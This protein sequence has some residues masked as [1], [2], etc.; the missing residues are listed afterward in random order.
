MDEVLRDPQPVPCEPTIEVSVEWFAIAM[1]AQAAVAE[2][3]AEIGRLQAEHDAMAKQCARLE[4]ALLPGNAYAGGIAVERARIVAWLRLGVLTES[5]E[6][7]RSLASLAD[8]F[9]SPG[10]G[11]DE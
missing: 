5:Q 4:Q 9:D 6:V 3:T 10:G 2:Q 1:Q 8:F 7:A 11:D